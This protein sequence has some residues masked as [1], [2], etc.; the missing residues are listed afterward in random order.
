MYFG[1]NFFF[2]M[3]GFTVVNVIQVFLSLVIFCLLVLLV[4]ER[5]VFKSQVMNVDFSLYFCQ[6]LLPIFLALLLGVGT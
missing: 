4:A 5:N 2:S 6:F 3:K 1:G